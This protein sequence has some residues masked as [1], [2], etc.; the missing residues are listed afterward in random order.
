V[1]TCE[2]L[3][4][5]QLDFDSSGCKI[6]IGEAYA[7]KFGMWYIDAVQILVSKVLA[8]FVAAVSVNCSMHFLPLD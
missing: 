7:A 3:L 6:W 2:R 1:K 8:S 5:N 4:E